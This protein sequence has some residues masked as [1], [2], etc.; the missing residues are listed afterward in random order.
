MI[1]GCYWAPEIHEIGGRLS[2]LFAPCFHPTDPQSNEGGAWSTVESHIMQLRDG[3]DPAN[4][5]DWS[6]PAAIRKVDGTALGRPGMPANISLDMSYFE[7]RGQGYYTWSQRYLPTSG[8]S[9]IH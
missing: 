9:A 3:G 4:P 5:A 1:A 8:R 2:I 7:V 6:K